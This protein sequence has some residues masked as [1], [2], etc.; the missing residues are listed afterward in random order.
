MKRLALSLAALLVAGCAAFPVEVKVCTDHPK[1]GE[2][3]LVIAKGVVRLAYT[4]AGEELS[5]EVTAD[6]AAW[7]AGEKR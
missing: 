6:L 5:A 3:C 4:K 7:Y 1:Y 2:V